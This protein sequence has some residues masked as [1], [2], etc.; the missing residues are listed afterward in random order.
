MAISIN[1]RDLGL[2][3]ARTTKPKKRRVLNPNDSKTEAPLQE[4]CEKWLEARGIVYLHI[5]AFL[6]NAGFTGG[7]KAGPEW[8]ARNNAAKDVRGFPDLCIFHPDA[9]HYIAVELKSRTGTTTTHQDEWLHALGGLVIRN[10]DEFVMIIEGWLKQ[11]EPE[12][13]E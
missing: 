4:A 6:L 13:K 1:P 7:A 11:P 5:P 9:L 2:K 8:Y 10:F 12:A 3:F